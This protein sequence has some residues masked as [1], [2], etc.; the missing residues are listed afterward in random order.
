[1]LDRSPLSLTHL[2]MT[3]NS[4]LSTPSNTN[5]SLTTN[6][7]IQTSTLMGLTDPSNNPIIQATATTNA[8]YNPNNDYVDT[9]GY[10]DTN[11]SESYNYQPVALTP[12]L[13]LFRYPGDDDTS[14]A[15]SNDQ[16]SLFHYSPSENGTTTSVSSSGVQQVLTCTN[17]EH[18]LAV[19]KKKRE[20]CLGE[21]RE[22][23]AALETLDQLGSRRYFG[24]ELRFDKVCLDNV[25]LS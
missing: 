16:E 7:I 1:M 4:N 13:S 2:T 14:S 23:D 19:L 9:P 10:E 6:P 25:S 18:M 12:Q 24:A 20:K 5:G 21:L 11:T 17:I 8:A 3:D 15:S 22:F